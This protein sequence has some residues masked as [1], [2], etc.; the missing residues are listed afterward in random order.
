M[1]DE[2]VQAAERRLRDPGVWRREGGG[3]RRDPAANRRRGPLEG[4]EDRVGVLGA[5]RGRDASRAAE[6]LC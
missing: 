6:A 5:Q 1:R 3:A 2:L 4:R